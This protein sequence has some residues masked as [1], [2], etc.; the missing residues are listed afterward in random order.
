MFTNLLAPSLAGVNHL[1]ERLGVLLGAVVALENVRCVHICFVF[2]NLLQR[3]ESFL[4][5]VAIVALNL[6]K[7]DKE[8]PHGTDLMSMLMR[9]TTNSLPRLR[10][11]YRPS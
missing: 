6:T 10:R 5:Y 3:Y 8:A 7:A 11:A 1:L 2:A 9:F 4:N